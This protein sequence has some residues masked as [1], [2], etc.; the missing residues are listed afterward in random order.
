MLTTLPL[1]RGLFFVPVCVG[2]VLMFVGFAEIFVR[3]LLNR[4][5]PL[6]ILGTDAPKPGGAE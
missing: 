1:P 2:A 4:L 5:A 3:A 6:D